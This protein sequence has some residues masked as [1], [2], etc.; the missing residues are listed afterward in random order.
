MPK[1][2]I[3]KLRKCKQNQCLFM[4]I[5]LSHPLCSM[6]FFP[7]SSVFC[8][9]G[10]VTEHG[11]PGASSRRH[12]ARLNR[13]GR[14][15]LRSSTGHHPVCATHLLRHDGGN[16]MSSQNVLILPFI[17][18]AVWKSCPTTI[19]TTTTIP[20]GLCSRKLCEGW[21]VLLFVVTA[22]PMNHSLFER[23]IFKFYPFLGE[24]CYNI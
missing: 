13:E 3:T 15:H 5:R 9:C 24:M 10:R 12:A 20:K 11:C 22:F 1:S 19:P 16:R 2:V 18:T 4:S 14:H 8:P 6:C 21:I 17:L 23:T 7:V